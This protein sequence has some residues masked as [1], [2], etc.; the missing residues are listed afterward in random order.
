MKDRIESR[1]R[2]ISCI[3]YKRR[4]TNWISYILRRTCLLKHVIEGRIEMTGRRGRKRKQL[5]DDLKETRSYWNLKEEA[6]DLV[7]WRTGFGR[8]YGL[9][10]RDYGINE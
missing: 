6:L 4:K 2:G 10:V 5:L 9:V 8:G 7:L 1:R 3:Q